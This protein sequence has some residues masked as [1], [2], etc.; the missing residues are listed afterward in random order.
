MQIKQ[1]S[2]LS[3]LMTFSG[4][5]EFYEFY[6]PVWRR[7]KT[8][9]QTIRQDAT[10]FGL[11]KTLH[12]EQQIVCTPEMS[13]IISHCRRQADRNSHQQPNQE[14][15]LLTVMDFYRQF[16]CAFLVCRALLIQICLFTTRLIVR[17]LE[18]LSTIEFWRRVFDVS[19]DL[20]DSVCMHSGCKRLSAN[21]RL[22]Q[23][24]F[25][26]SVDGRYPYLSH[27][28]LASTSHRNTTDKPSLI[29]H[30]I[31]G[32]FVASPLAFP[33]I[34]FL[35]ALW[36]ADT[37]THT[38]TFPF[39]DR[40][41]LQLCGGESCRLREALRCLRI[42]YEYKNGQLSR[43]E[44]LSI[45]QLDNKLRPKQCSTSQPLCRLP[46]NPNNLLLGFSFLPLPLSAG[47]RFDWVVL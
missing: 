13:E 45:S 16:G 31:R 3:D 27:L 24:L 35:S 32:S 20:C 36:Q 18:V 47:I 21:D 22:G 37:H 46:T 15:L 42:L 5:V 38:C 29:A 12:V 17:L 34:N 19:D 2:S 26:Y 1:N 23:G 39:S 40:I 43:G 14:G 41:T 9:S 7:K 11:M 44:L 10:Q 8:R 28:H 4:N 30:L 6:N 25:V 33:R